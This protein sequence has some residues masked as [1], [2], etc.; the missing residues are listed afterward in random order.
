MSA[1]HRVRTSEA[2]SAKGLRPVLGFVLGVPLLIVAVAIAARDVPGDL[3]ALARVLAT[4][5][6][7][8]APGGEERYVGRGTYLGAPAAGG[9]DELCEIWAEEGSGRGG[10]TRSGRVVLVPPDARIEL[11]GGAVVELGD[12]VSVT[13]FEGP[14]LEPERAHRLRVLHLGRIPYGQRLREHCVARGSE[15]F[16]DG[17]I[18]GSVIAG[19]SSRDLAITEGT[20]ARRI[21]PLLGSVGWSLL[22]LDVFAFA[23]LALARIRADQRAGVLKRHA[24]SPPRER[25]SAA[26]LIAWA[27]VLAA[28][29]MAVLAAGLPWAL[30]AGAL[31]FGAALFGASFHAHESRT[32]QAL[33]SKVNA[34][35]TVPLAHASGASAEIAATAAPSA[36]VLGALSKRP[37]ALVTLH[38]WRHELGPPQG[39]YR[40]K[41]FVEVG[42]RTLPSSVLPIRDGSGSGALDLTGAVLD[43]PA[44]EALYAHHHQVPPEIPW[45]LGHPLAPGEYLVREGYLDFGAPLYLLGTVE[46]VVERAAGHVSFRAPASQAHVSASRDGLLVFGGTEGNLRSFLAG[47]R[48][49]GVA[50]ALL[51]GALAALTLAALAG[52]V[53]LGMTA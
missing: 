37:R 15:I 13:P 20:R 34:M 4:D 36:G 14:P 39:R 52:A 16:L 11:D 35:P 51:H 7:G 5:G 17:C 27:A 40:S 6:R 44:V 31:G 1:V 50:F 49:T 18:A 30:L 25:R 53:Y 38:V 48:R 45:L 19:C 22:I 10:W 29:L 33:E 26:W 23:V 28:T 32:L 8:A 3:I 12:P 21:L 43:L 41:I 2:P 46:R 47:F 24:K 42:T 9:S